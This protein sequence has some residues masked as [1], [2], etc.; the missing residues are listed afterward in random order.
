MTVI[1]EAADGKFE[2]STVQTKPGARTMTVDPS[3]HTIYLPTAEF[4]PAAAGKRP[5]MK[6]GTFMIV[7]V[8]PVSK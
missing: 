1:K 5:A 4:Q 7:V 2:A 3:T 8:G 6:P